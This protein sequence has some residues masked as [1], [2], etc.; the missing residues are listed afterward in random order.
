MESTIYIK[1]KLNSINT[2]TIEIE[3]AF[4]NNF[5]IVAYDNED[6]VWIEKFADT[7]EDAKKIAEK[8]NIKISKEY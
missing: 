6:S 1:K 7:Y 3:E 2:L 5:S 4:N 8:L